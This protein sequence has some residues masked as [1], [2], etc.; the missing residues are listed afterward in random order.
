MD[1]VEAKF[2][3]EKEIY[4]DIPSD[5]L[6]FLLSEVIELVDK[7]EEERDVALYEAEQCNTITLQL[8]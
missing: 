1:K 8:L 4:E 5:K 6:D 7:A 3:E 2:L